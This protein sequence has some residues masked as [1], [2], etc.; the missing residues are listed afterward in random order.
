MKAFDIAIKDVKQAFRNKTALMFM[1]VVPILV[2][3]MF[4][5]IFGS[6]D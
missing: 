4:L 2:T 5:F 1:F 3:G 6:G